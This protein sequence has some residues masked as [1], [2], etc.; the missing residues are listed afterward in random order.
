MYGVRVVSK[1]P[2][3]LECFYRKRIAA[4]K[5]QGEAVDWKHCHVIRFLVK[6]FPCHFD[7]RYVLFVGQKYVGLL[8]DS[9]C[10]KRFLSKYMVI[11]Y[12]G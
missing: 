12:Q 2:L 1:L 4:L 7:Y 8:A 10:V 3:M 11:I 6:E 9:A 5:V